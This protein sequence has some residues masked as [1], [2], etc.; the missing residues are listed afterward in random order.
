MRSHSLNR[1]VSFAQTLRYL[2]PDHAIVVLARTY[3]LSLSLS[4]GPAIV[5]ILASK[6]SLVGV[7]KAIGRLIVRHLSWAGFPFSITLALA[8]RY[9]PHFLLR[10]D[11]HHTQTHTSTEGLVGSFATSYIAMALLQHGRRNHCSKGLAD[12][13]IL[14]LTVPQTFSSR[15]EALSPT[16]D[17]TLIILVRALDT[18]VQRGIKA[19]TDKGELEDDAKKDKLTGNVDA[20]MFWVASSRYNGN[21]SSQSQVLTCPRIMWCFFYEPTSLPASY[22]K[23]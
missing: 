10:L 6:R 20:A 7:K 22:L 11:G 15:K 14:P 12:T 9:L 5:S 18:W 8:G 23:W 2:P 13:S 4:L 19:V 16:W 17:L 1:L 21:Y 3:I